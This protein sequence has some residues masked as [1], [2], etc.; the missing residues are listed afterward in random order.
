MRQWRGGTGMLARGYYKGGFEPKINR[1]EAS[2]ILE[3]P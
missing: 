2:L 3:L 1:R